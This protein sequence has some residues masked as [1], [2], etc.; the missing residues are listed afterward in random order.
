[1][2]F[3]KQFIINHKLFFSIVCLYFLIRLWNLTL[4][5]IFNDEAIYLDWGWRSITIPGQLF[6]S[7]YDAKQ[8]LLMWVFGVSSSIFTD[9]LFG[10][11]VVSVVTGFFTMLGL[12]TVGRHYFDEKIGLLAAFLYTITPVFSFYDRQALMES[13]VS[14]IGVWF[15]YFS[16]CLLKTWETKYVIYMGILFGIGFFVK[17]TVIAFLLGSLFVSFWVSIQYK[18]EQR[19]ILVKQLLVFLVISQLILLPLYIQPVFWETFYTNSRYTL[20][21]QEIFQLP[22]T[23]WIKN[24]WTFLQIAFGYLTP[25]IFIFALFGFYLLFKKNKIFVFWILSIL[26]CLVLLGRGV[27]IRYTTPFLPLFLL[28]ASFAIVFLYQKFPK[29]SALVIFISLIGSG[30]LTFVQITDPLMYF[31]YIEKITKISEK[32]EY[33][34]YWTA[35]FGVREIFDTIQLQSNNKPI[36]IAVRPDSGNPENAMFVYARKNNNITPLYFSKEIAEQTLPGASCIR[37][38]KPFFFVSRDD[39]LAGLEKDI[40]E[41]KRVY[42]PESKHY[43]GLYTLKERQDCSEKILIL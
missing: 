39:Q 10:G 12:Y 24:I 13:T 11:R 20:T 17:S 37:S 38:Q 27:T 40:V 41:I 3:I 26:L 1:M 30:Y 35:G 21:L 42:K 5:P 15:C 16:L 28:A 23:I 18:K 32:E 8:P 36:Y 22:F 43:V 31:N 9:P 4:L 14:A 19:K 25:G 6:Y 2:S 33:V 29:I 7:L 34:K